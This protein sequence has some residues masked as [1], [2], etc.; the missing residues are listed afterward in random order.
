LGPLAS[1]L[2]TAVASLFLAASS[3]A[4]VARLQL[5]F[6]SYRLL[7]AMLAQAVESGPTSGTEHAVQ[8]LSPLVRALDVKYRLE[9]ERRLGRSVSQ[10][11]SRGMFNAVGL[12]IALDAADL[13]ESIGRDDVAGW[14]SATVAARKARLDY[15]LLSPHVRAPLPILDGQIRAQLDALLAKL[16][17]SDLTTSPSGIE[18]RR[19]AAL[20]AL[21]ALRGALAGPGIEPRREGR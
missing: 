13:L 4:D 9:V 16:E 14:G 21:G 2:A 3:D 20:E 6:A 12:L 15:E 1:H 8:A 11:D 17:S 5:G 7:S 19:A 18:E 10:C